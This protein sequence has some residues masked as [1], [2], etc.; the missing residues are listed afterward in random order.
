MKTFHFTAL[1]AVALSIIGPAFAYNL[2]GV[3][4]PNGDIPM[5]LELGSPPSTLADGSNNW[6]DVA[7]AAMNIWNAD[8]KRSRFVGNKGSTAPRAKKNGYSTVQFDSTIYGEA[9]G[10]RVLAVT[11]RWVRG[12][13]VIE[14]DVIV[15]NARTWDS[16]R[17][18]LRSGRTELQR[19]LIHEFG[20]TLGLLHPDE[21]DPVQTVQ[22]I[23]NSTISNVEVP[24]GDDLAA[25]NQLYSHTLV[26]PTSS[27]KFT[28]QTI[29]AGQPLDLNFVAEGT[30]LVYYWFFTPP[31]GDYR[32]LLN[33]DGEYWPDGHFKLFSVQAEDAGKYEVAAVNFNGLSPSASSTVTV[34]PV[35]TANALLANLSARGRAGSGDD[36]FIVGFVVTG[37]TPKQVLVRAIGPALAAQG[38]GAPLADPKLKL[39][40]MSGGTST[41]V[42]ENDNWSSVPDAATVSATASRVGAFALTSGSKDAALLVTLAPGVY[43]A[44]VDA[45]GGTPGIALVEVYDTDQTHAGS[46]AHRLINVSTRS[47]V[48]TGEEKLFGGFVVDGPGP[49]QVLIRAIGPGLAKLGVNG[50][51]TDPNLVIYKN[52]VAIAD[53]DDWAFSNQTDL[54]PA[55]CK[56]LGAFALEEGS[57]D[58]ALLITLPPGVYSAQIAGRHDETGVVLLEVYEVPE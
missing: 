25:I 5:Q 12:I 6:D 4:W 21:D 45:Q 8:L 3:A 32:L 7:L 56:K 33:G 16:Y 46:L 54:L 22:A 26:T 29:D 35:S 55:V 27:T 58:S 17:G 2:S 19:V 40:R 34:K 48:G 14:S 51:N 42:G 39:F 36:T 44:Q 15:N 20:H 52:G 18:N 9:F 10:E 57:Y 53:N 38:I 31:G 37:D 11:Y 24:Q 1:A 28:D 30:D 50:V 23:M 47:Y 41:Q 13:S 49:K 43:S